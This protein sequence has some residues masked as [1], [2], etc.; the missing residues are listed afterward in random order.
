MLT[1]GRRELYVNLP[2]ADP[3]ASRAFFGGLGF[4]FEPR[5]SNDAAACMI[6]GERAYVMLLQRSFFQTFTPRAI[7][8]TS[9]SLQG[10]LAFS[11]GSRREVDAVVDRAVEAGGAEAREPTDHGFMYGRSFFDPD[12][13]QW[14]VLWVEPQ[15][16][17]GGRA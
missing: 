13:H 15:A 9:R 6:V 1:P 3:A 2:V 12:G 4:A 17:T 16:A 5:F 7:C 14:E 11:A 10:L 8:D